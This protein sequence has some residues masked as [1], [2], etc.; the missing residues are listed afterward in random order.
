MSL[1][2]ADRQTCGAE[3]ERRVRLWGNEPR[4]ACQR[5]AVSD[6]CVRLSSLTARSDVMKVCSRRI[7]VRRP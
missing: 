5:L 6:K 3:P 7:E 2:P 4:A 1:A